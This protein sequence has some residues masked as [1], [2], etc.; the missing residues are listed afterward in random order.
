MP[1]KD[2]QKK[3]ASQGDLF[4][5]IVK[6]VNDSVEKLGAK[7]GAK[8]TCRADPANDAEPGTLEQSLDAIRNPDGTGTTKV[9]QKG[10]GSNT[11]EDISKPKGKSKSKQKPKKRRKGV[12]SPEDVEREARS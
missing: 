4:E 2:D 8:V 10:L 6:K 12:R 11:F 1:M 5:Q 9:S 7:L 3:D